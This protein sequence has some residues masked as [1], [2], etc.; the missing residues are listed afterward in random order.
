MSRLAERPA[1]T[2]LA[3]LKVAALHKRREI[4][5]RRREGR[6]TRLVM[7]AVA[8]WLVARL[9][10]VK[11]LRAVHFYTSRRGPLMAAGISFN[12]FFAMAAMLVAVFSILGLVAAGNRKLQGLVI[13]GVDRQVPNL[14]G[15]EGEGLVTSEQ[16]FS[17]GGNL[18]IAL[19]IA[20]ATMLWT[21]LRWIGSLRQ[22]MRAIFDLE[23]L[24]ANP[25]VVVLKD[26]AI[27]FVLGVAMV[28][29][30][31]V[32]IVVNTLLD[33]FIELLDLG[34]FAGFLTRIAGILV[35]LLLDMAVA[36]ILFRHASRIPM[37]RTAMLQSAL[38]AAV[39]S[40]LLRTFSTLL[41]RFVGN[42]PLLDSF[43]VILGLFLWFYLLSQL[44]LAAAAW[45][46]V[47]TADTLASRRHSR[48]D[49]K[50]PSLRQRA[51]EAGR[52]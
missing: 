23:P 41:L 29:T 52:T 8:S 42:N 5:K 44:Y 12:L 49:H 13:E 20:T 35:M 31:G 21:S 9:R 2:E 3:K 47:C 28:V 36:V 11:P 25:L 39:G 51:R 43:A 37:P 27:L 50:M 17:A 4:G 32:G 26:L 7:V 19:V 16:L 15:G 18:S 1:P 22:G 48:K 46:A 33:T 30:L 34:T 6:G 10:T 38:V 24:E 40:T 45:G 14:I